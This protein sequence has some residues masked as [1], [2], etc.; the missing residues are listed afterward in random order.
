MKELFRLKVSDFD[1]KS[2]TLFVRQGKGGKDRI[3]PLPMIA[4]GYLKEYVERVRPKFVKAMKHDDG[5]LFLTYTGCS[6]SI[7]SMT[8]IFKRTT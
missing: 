1:L 2:R 4:A 8:N 3:L 6:L 7:N 5:I